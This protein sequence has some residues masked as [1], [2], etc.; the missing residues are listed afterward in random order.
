MSVVCVFD[1]SVNKKSQNVYVSVYKT[2]YF[3]VV[4]EV[5]L[6]LNYGILGRSSLFT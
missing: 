5:I 4:S 3:Y 1:L 2:T 6:V